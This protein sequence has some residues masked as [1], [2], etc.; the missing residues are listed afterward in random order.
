[1][2]SRALAKTIQT[3]TPAVGKCFF[4][5]LALQRRELGGTADAILAAGVPPVPAIFFNA[6]S[7][8]S[9]LNPNG[10]GLLL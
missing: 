1:M 6:P 8:S 10:P 7:N 5:A 9:G 4:V 3:T 2:M